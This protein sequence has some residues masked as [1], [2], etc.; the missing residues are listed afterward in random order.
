MEAYTYF[1]WNEKGSG[2]VYT[3]STKIKFKELIKLT[4]EYGNSFVDELYKKTGKNNHYKVYSYMEL[5]GESL[6]INI[7]KQIGDT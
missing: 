6:I 4:T 5:Q 3:L 7:H 1:L 2:T